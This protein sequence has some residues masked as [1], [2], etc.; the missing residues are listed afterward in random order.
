MVN[1]NNIITI[2]I[3]KEYQQYSSP[4]TWWQIKAIG[5][6]MPEDVTSIILAKFDDEKK[7]ESVFK[8]IVN[9]ICEQKLDLVVI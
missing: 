7:C 8:R 9:E 2:Y 4:D 1:Y 6:I 5:T 3:D